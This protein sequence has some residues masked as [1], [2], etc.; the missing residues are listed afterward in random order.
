M[1][2]FKWALFRRRTSSEKGN[3]E[4]TLILHAVL[5][6]YFL[7]CFALEVPCIQLVPK[8][9]SLLEPEPI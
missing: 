1:Q 8:A 2:L 7:V 6:I 4:P 9:C 3:E 5:K